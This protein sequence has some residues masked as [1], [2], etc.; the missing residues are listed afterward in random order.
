MA[1]PRRPGRV[2]TVMRPLVAVLVLCGCGS[3]EPPRE[4]PTAPTVAPLPDPLLCT[5][6]WTGDAYISYGS[7]DDATLAVIRDYDITVSGESTGWRARVA[8]PALARV[9]EVAV[10]WNRGQGDCFATVEIA[11]ADTTVRYYLT[12]GFVSDIHIANPA[13][14]C[15]AQTGSTAP[16]TFVPDNAQPPPPPPARAAAVGAYE[17]AVSWIGHACDAL[18]PPPGQLAFQLAI[19]HDASD[20]LR[21]LGLVGFAISDLSLS[22]DAT[23]DAIVIRGSTLTHAPYPVTRLVLA[24]RVGTSAIEG[25]ATYQRLDYGDAVLCKYTG[26]IRG[27]RR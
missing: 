23:G 27:H 19:D 3:P 7:C 8:K 9:N 24:L 26:R 21:P 18:A 17:L 13:T 20:Q 22:A 2:L 12:R 11:V 6:R 5:G 16:A 10:G 25:D 1:G 14:G 15:K 4:R